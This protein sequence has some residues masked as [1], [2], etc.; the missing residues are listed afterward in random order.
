MAA[1]HQKSTRLLGHAQRLGVA[2][3]PQSLFM[4]SWSAELLLTLGDRLKV[5]TA[6]R[7]ERK[8]L[9][10]IGRALAAV[11]ELLDELDRALDGALGSKMAMRFRLKAPRFRRLM[12]ASTA[13]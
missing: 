6:P 7:E 2:F 11:R 1:Y 8:V 3:E 13:S 9:Q 12:Q 4:L 10:K 5:V